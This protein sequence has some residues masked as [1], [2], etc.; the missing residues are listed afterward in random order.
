CAGRGLIRQRGGDTSHA[1]GA[2]SASFAR[3]YPAHALPDSAQE[4]S[5]TARERR[6]R[7]RPLVA[8]VP[9]E[10][11]DQYRIGWCDVRVKLPGFGEESAKSAAI[12]AEEFSCPIGRGGQDVAT[13]SHRQ[14]RLI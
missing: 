3:G 6:Y 9:G 2:L 7:L 11:G 4:M 13:V 5:G 1:R 8:D 14:A 12:R 10:G